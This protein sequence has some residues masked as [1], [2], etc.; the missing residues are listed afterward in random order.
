MQVC[1]LT[2]PCLPV[3]ASLQ[4]HS[5]F[6]IL[7]QGRAGKRKTHRKRNA[8]VQAANPKSSGESIVRKTTSKNTTSAQ[9]NFL[10]KVRRDFTVECAQSRAALKLR[11]TALQLLL[12]FVLG[13]N[14]EH[15]R[16]KA[17]VV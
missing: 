13:H 15:T 6:H 12:K 16:Q 14:A 9:N 2:F 10:H 4:G 5:I 1:I 17:A 8:T 7:C 3:F 11:Q